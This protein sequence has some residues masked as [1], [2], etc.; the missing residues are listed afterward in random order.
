MPIEI[1][2]GGRSYPDAAEGL[3]QFGQQLLDRWNGQ[4]KTISTELA[5]FLNDVAKQLATLHGKAWPGGTSSGSLS[6]RSGALIS[7]ILAGVKVEGSTIDA[8]VGTFSI[9]APYAIHEFGGT[10]RAKG[11]KFM[12]IPLPEAL[13]SKG[14]PKQR[15]PRDW[16]NTFVA[17][18]R[19]GNLL[20]FQR[21][22]TT[23]VPLYVLKTSVTLTARLHAED[24]LTTNLPHFLD[25]LVDQIAASMGS[26]MTLSIRQQILNNMLAAFAAVSTA[27]GDPLTFSTCVLGP[28]G[29][30]DQRKRYSL[31]IVAGK[32]KF[33]DKFSWYE[34]FLPVGI[35]Y[36]ITINKGDDAPAS[37]AETLLTLVKQV[38]MKDPSW[39]GIAI[40]TNL[41]SDEV[42]LTTYADRSVEGVLHVQLH[43]RHSRNDPTD[44]TPSF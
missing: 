3:N 15:S 28:L 27:N 1:E 30:Q 25:R 11:G 18:S 40:D 2:I 19:N 9:P 16:Q 39:G 33:S 5:A 38:V 22:G 4:I 6:T 44:P 13:D 42:D 37:E 36:R 26:P 14:T 41:V 31:G 21:R 8:L 10:M 32:E 35:E 43:Y 24:T 23:I 34:C 29:A 20:I 17:R 7:G 12:A